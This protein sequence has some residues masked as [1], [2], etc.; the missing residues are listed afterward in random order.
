MK[1]ISKKLFVSTLLS[2]ILIVSAMPVF[3]QIE[4]LQ[5][6]GKAADFIADTSAEP[7]NPAEIVG[8]IIGIVLSVLGVIAVILIL[9]SGFIWMTAAGN[10]E[11]IDKA[12]KIL[13]NA[14]VGLIIIL[15]AYSITYFVTTKLLEASR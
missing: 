12:K 11:K 14:I 13:G 15:M 4:D 1:F 9:Y 2:L 10:T 5:N 8:S 3:A 7:K 6:F